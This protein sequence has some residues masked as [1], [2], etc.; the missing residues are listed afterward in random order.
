MQIQKSH[1]D[2]FTNFH[3]AIQA[4]YFII[5]LGLTTFWLHPLIIAASFCG[6]LFYS[7]NLRGWRHVLRLLLTFILP[8]AVVVTLFN[9]AFNHYGSTALITFNSG[10]SITLES[11]IY[12]LVL[13][14]V[15]GGNLLWFVAINALMTRDKIVYLTGRTLPTI[16]LLFSLTFRFVPLLGQQLKVVHRAQAGIGNTPAQA[17]WRN[18]VTAFSQILNILSSWALETAIT[19]ADTMRSRGYGSGRATNFTRYQF[20]WLDVLAALVLGGL[21]GIS[22]AAWFMHGLNATYAMQVTISH[23]IWTVIGG[24]PLTLMMLLPALLHTGCG[25]RKKQ[26]PSA[27]EF[28]PYFARQT[29]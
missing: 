16:G 8:G 25:F 10:T 11:I 17:T 14:S 20:C 15:L 2:P 29:N 21:F 23:N 18:K 26:A 4:S 7:G 6:A 27:P 22:V 13:A 9:A 28:P 12:G 1:H 19:T 3:P 24:I 5:V